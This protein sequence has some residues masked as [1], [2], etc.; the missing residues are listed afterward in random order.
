MAYIKPTSFFKSFSGKVI[1]EIKV[2]IT[3]E[4]HLHMSD[5]EWIGWRLKGIPVRSA[6]GST[7]HSAMHVWVEIV[8][9]AGERHEY[10]P[11]MWSPIMYN[12]PDKE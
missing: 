6:N 7:I 8:T 1:D 5:I 10:T 3:D 2:W 11:S 9:Y 12:A 4:L